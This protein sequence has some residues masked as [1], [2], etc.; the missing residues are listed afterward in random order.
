MEQLVH[1]GNLLIFASFAVVDILWLRVLQIVASAAFIGYF[2]A[3]DRSAPIVWNVAFI[4]LN[5]VHTLRL[6]HQRRPVALTPE[7][8]R[9]YLRV[10]RSL[11]RR[12]F[13]TL[14]ERGAWREAGGGD[15]LVAQGRPPNDLYLVTEGRVAVVV[16]DDEVARMGP[17]N[18]VG[19]MS[20]F[21]KHP[22]TADVHALSRVRMI[23]WPVEPLRRF[24]DGQPELRAK[25]ER[26]IGA[27]VI[28]KVRASHLAVNLTLERATNGELRI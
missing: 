27:D 22:P 26:V 1:L 25:I 3:L 21:T 23:A 10:F 28:D 19:E 18:F 9:I 8:E 24:L 13:L 12:E 5:L 2:I 4:A 7:Q 14:F 11:T 20:F 17:G 6:I 15:I 16:K